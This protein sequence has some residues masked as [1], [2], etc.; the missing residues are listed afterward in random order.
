MLK[1]SPQS[2]R[3]KKSCFLYSSDSKLCSFHSQY[4]KLWFCENQRREDTFQRLYCV[5][6]ECY[7]CSCCTQAVLSHFTVLSQ[8]GLLT[9]WQ[10]PT[11]GTTYNCNKPSLKQHVIAMFSHLHGCSHG[12]T[13]HITT[14]ASPAYRFTSRNNQ[15]LGNNGEKQQN[16]S[17]NS[18]YL[19]KKGFNLV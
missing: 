17:T 9:E 4:K 19:K 18:N 13:S 7:D 2:D 6:T 12:Y 11:T 16:K 15:R 3:I 14:V 1:N 5:M 8:H 10:Q